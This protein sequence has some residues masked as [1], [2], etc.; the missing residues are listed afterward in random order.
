MSRC[1]TLK[2]NS[3]ATPADICSHRCAHP[4]WL[5]LLPHLCCCCQHCYPCAAIAAA[6]LH[7]FLWP[8]GVKAL[9]SYFL[10]FPLFSADG[11]DDDEN[12]VRSAR[13]LTSITSN[14]DGIPLLLSKFHL[15]ILKYCT[16]LSRDTPNPLPV[17]FTCVLLYALSLV[18]LHCVPL[19]KCSRLIHWPPPRSSNTLHPREFL[20]YGDGENPRNSDTKSSGCT[21]LLQVTNVDGPT[22]PVAP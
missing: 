4:M 19:H 9:A 5:R 16:C 8:K 12:F 10:S 2:R 1:F 13:G 22:T 17:C 21:S 14:C 3:M 18:I 6:A 20:K 15:L 7:K 11:V